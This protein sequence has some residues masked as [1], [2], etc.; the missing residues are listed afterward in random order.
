ML[1]EYSVA[2]SG[3]RPSRRLVRHYVVV[4]EKVERVNPIALGPRDFVNEWI[5]H[6]WLESS[7][8]TEPEKCASQ[9][10]V[11]SDDEKKPA[12]AY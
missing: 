10:G 3:V 7:P 12:K 5:M 2:L 1:V 11:D 8:W 4:K 6:P 9:V